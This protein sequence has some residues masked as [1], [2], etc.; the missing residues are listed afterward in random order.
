MD[1]TPY[2]DGLRNDLVDAASAGGEQ[3]RDA[4]ERLT[5]ALAPATRLAL[6]EAISQAAAEITSEM[7]HGGVDVRLN[8]RELD[9][10]VTQDDT[11]PAPPAPP[12]PPSPPEAEEDDGGVARVSLRLPE[13]VKV[14]AEELATTSGQSLNSWLVNAI[15]A[16]TQERAID[17]D[18]DVTSFPFPGGD[19]FGRGRGPRRM[20]GWV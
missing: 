10:M 4:A 16:A 6:M 13:S 15:R 20:T 17:V 3:T 11:P 5:L 7:R 18:L 8:G 12:A 14:R 9:F 2:V 1:I 19:P